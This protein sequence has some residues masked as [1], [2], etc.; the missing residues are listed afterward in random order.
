MAVG[1]L[2]SDVQKVSFSFQPAASVQIC[3]TQ[4]LCSTDAS[5]ARL[6]G[7][8]DIDTVGNILYT[9][10]NNSADGGY[11]MSFWAGRN[12]KFFIDNS[13]YLYYYSLSSVDV[14][15][16]GIQTQ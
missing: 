8:G 2:V 5:N 15:F 9:V 11:Y 6:Q 14:G 13:S 7:L 1:D 4:F 10:R 3:I 12:F 16:S